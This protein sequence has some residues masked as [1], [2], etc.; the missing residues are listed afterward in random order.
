MALMASHRS[1]SR[2]SHFMFNPRIIGIVDPQ[3]EQDRLSDD[4]VSEFELFF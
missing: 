3:W 2:F 1:D 4:D